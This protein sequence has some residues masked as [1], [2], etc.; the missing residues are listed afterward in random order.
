MTTTR[1]LE[2]LRRQWL[3]VVVGVLVT[4][5]AFVLLQRLPGLYYSETQ[6]RFLAPQSA[7]F[8][9]VLQVTSDNLISAA[10]IVKT[11]VVDGATQTAVSSANVTLVGEGVTDGSSVRLPDIG[12][13]W[14]HNFASPVLD[15]QVVGHSA[16][17]V[18]DRMTALQMKVSN[19]LADLQRQQGVSPENYIRAEPSP[20]QVVVTYLAPQ[21]KRAALG[22][23]L[24]AIPLTM[25]LAVAIDHRRLM[26]SRQR[27]LERIAS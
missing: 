9:N 20:Q 4:G 15:I 27:L 13:Q 7:R 3:V 26:R 18:R 21:W 25:G 24:L 12:G 17:D 6:M 5:V 8:P 1:V 19:T 14:A 16:D 23:A 10:G 2:A 22:V 11:I